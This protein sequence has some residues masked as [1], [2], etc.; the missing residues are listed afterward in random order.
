MKNTK[1]ALAI[2]LLCGALYACKKEAPAPA[3]EAPPAATEPA[4]DTM[5][6][7]T[8]P[9]DTTTTPM[10]E[11]TPAPED[12]AQPADDTDDDSPQSGGDKVGTGN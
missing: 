12:A 8:T 7:D 11:T 10:D 1:L 5:P 3:E 9:A 6:A 2:I 4:A